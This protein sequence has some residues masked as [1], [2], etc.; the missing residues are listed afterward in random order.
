MADNS[1]HVIK[2]T[3]HHVNLKTT[4][5]QEMIDWYGTVVGA[6]PNFQNPI[7][8]LI[9]NDDANHRIALLAVLELHDDPQKFDHTGIHHTAFEYASFDDLM[10]TYTRLKR[11]GIVPRLP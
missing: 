4:K 7:L 10:S 1:E 3:M 9:T 11:A 8:A 6:K 2:P 5:L